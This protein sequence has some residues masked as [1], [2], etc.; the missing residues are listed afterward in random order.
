MSLYKSR[1]STRHTALE[2]FEDLLVL[3]LDTLDGIGQDVGGHWNQESTSS[4][5]QL[6]L[7]I[8][9]FLF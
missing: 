5:N 7:A 3:L 9:Q 4:A 1:W 2:T 6:A 8:R